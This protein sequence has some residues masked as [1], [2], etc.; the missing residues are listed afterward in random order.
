MDKMTFSEFVAKLQEEPIMQCS[1]DWEE[2]L[3]P[4]LYAPYKALG[5]EEVAS[6]LQVDKHRHYETSITVLR[7]DEG[8]LG[9]HLISDTFSEMC[10]VEDCCEE[11]GFYLM[12]AV[13][14]TS[15]RK[16]EEGV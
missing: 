7:C 8:L 2:D 4:V 5:F 10:E 11:Y 12:E 14:T 16:I 3:S 6:G 1:M 15:Y 13:Q 9:V